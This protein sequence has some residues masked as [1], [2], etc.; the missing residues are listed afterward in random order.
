LAAAG[1]GAL[2][3]AIVGVALGRI[4]RST[5]RGWED[6]P[7]QPL[8]RM[9]SAQNSGLTLVGAAV[10]AIVGAPVSEELLF[11]SVLYQPMRARIGVVPAAVVVGLLFAALHGYVWGVPL[12]LVLSVTFT[13]LFERTGSLWYPIA[14]HALYNGAT[15]LLVRLV[16]LPGGSGAV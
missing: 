2:T 16:S 15:F 13:A 11:R 6:F 7:V 3:F 10:L 9:I 5:G 1:A 14:A 4:V 12:L 8:V